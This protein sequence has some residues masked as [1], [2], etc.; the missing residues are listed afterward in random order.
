MP[1]RLGIYLMNT[2]TDPDPSTG[3]YV[4]ERGQKK[5]PLTL[6][7]LETMRQDGALTQSTLLWIDGMADWEP[8]SKVVPQIFF[9]AVQGPAEATR[10]ELQKVTLKL[11]HPKWRIL[12]GLIDACVVFLPTQIILIPLGVFTA[13]F[14]FAGELIVPVLFCVYEAL[15]MASNWQ[16][17]MGMKVLGLKVVDYSGRKLSFGQSFGRAA[18]SLVSALPFPPFCVGYWMIF[19]TQRQQ[20]L[21]DIIAGTL[22]VRTKEQ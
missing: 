15:L 5:G 14:G 18:A 7:A 4:V 19:F 22:V 13:G 6:S 17:T 20:T 16:G 11:A 2:S 3:Y 8:A 12:G 10:S 1:S 21:H 9:H